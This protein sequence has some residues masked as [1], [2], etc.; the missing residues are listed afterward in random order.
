MESVVVPVVKPVGLTPLEAIQRFKTLNPQFSQEKIS[1]AGRLDPMAEGILLLLIGEE[2][3]KR[4]MYESLKKTYETDI[5]LGIET[6]S[7]DALGMVLKVAEDSH[8]EKKEI[9]S[10]LKG[11]VGRTMQ[12]YPPYSS[13]PVGGKPLFWWARNGRLSEIEIPCKEIEI[14]GCT[15]LKKTHMSGSGLFADVMERIEKITGDFRQKEIKA[16]WREFEKDYKNDSFAKITLKVSCSSG[17]Y[18][19][20]LADDIGKKL[21]CGA[22]ALSI[23]RI[24]VGKHTLSDCLEL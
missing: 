22:F 8:K 2:N 9:L 23:N 6:D 1:Y 10:C 7:F 16:C 4:K 13:K 14:S 20:R 18:I 11:F 24:S 5:I 3:K 17:T 12:E 19:R 21:G 15:F